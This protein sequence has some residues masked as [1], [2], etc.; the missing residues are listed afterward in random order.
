MIKAM[1]SELSQRSP[2]QEPVQY[3]VYNAGPWFW[4]EAR[5]AVTE[6]YK[7]LKA[8]SRLDVYSPLHCMSLNCNVYLDLP[9]DAKPE[10]Y[11]ARA[12]TRT[13][14]QQAAVFEEDVQQVWDTDFIVAMIEQ[15]D[16]GTIFELAGGYFLRRIRKTMVP[17]LIAWSYEP[18]RNANLMI[19]RSVDAFFNT[20]EQVHE[21]INRR[22][23]EI[24]R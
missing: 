22:I 10:D 3:K 23:E 7:E 17:W 13:P 14:S 4:R 11:F 16:P 15:W 19:A 5:I 6:M 21:A 9:L 1:T 2:F 20:P 24:E 8:D 12:K 18:A